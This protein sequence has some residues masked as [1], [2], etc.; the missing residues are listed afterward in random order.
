MGSLPFALV[1]TPR[2][3]PRDLG[4]HDLRRRRLLPRRA[5]AF[6]T[7]AQL[8]SPAE[9]RGRVLSVHTVILGSLYPLGAVSRAR[10]PTASASASTTLGAAALLLA[11]RCSRRVSCGRASPRRRSTERLRG[12]AS[13]AWLSSNS[14][15][16]GTIALLTLNRP[17]ARN[18]INPEVS[19]TMAGILDEF[20][21][22]PALRAVVLTGAGD[23]FSTGAD[24]KVV[25]Q[26]GANDIAAG[27][28][29]SR[30]SSR[31]TSRSRSSPRSTVPRS[32]VDSRSCCRAISSSRPTPRASASPR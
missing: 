21:A 17:E 23:V 5:V 30:V 6:T 11:V 27:R 3:D 22:D 16:R 8:R 9:I 10:S 18:A 4:A 12:V 29:V 15:E 31:A 19:Q 7:I 20:E 28:A 32:R 2:T 1:P 25:A 13:A 26:G 14:N 24:L